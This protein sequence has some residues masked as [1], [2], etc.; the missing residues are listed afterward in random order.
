M[1][2]QIPYLLW[3]YFF[4]LKYRYVSYHHIT[5]RKKH[6]IFYSN[7][8]P[9]PIT[10][11]GICTRWQSTLHDILRAVSRSRPERGQCTEHVD[12][13][14]KYGDGRGYRIRNIKNG[15]TDLGMPGYE[16]QLTNR[17]IAMIVDFIEQQEK[18]V[19]QP[20]TPRHPTSYK[21]WT[22]ISMSISGSRT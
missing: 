2:L 13:I 1:S 21:H 5:L 22:T 6:E 7:L 4:H 19:G 11:P 3:H 12:G 18:E 20:Q 10:S 9:E 17:Q 14:W 8:Y 16:K 15:L